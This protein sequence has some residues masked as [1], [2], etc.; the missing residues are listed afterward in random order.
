M[1]INSIASLTAPLSLLIDTQGY[2][3]CRSSKDSP[4]S[5][6]LINTSATLIRVPFRVKSPLALPGIASIYFN[7]LSYSMI[8]V[9]S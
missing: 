7:L 9:R 1:L 8:I 3:S 4:T 2:I 6:S 5:V